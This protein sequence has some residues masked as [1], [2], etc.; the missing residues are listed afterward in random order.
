MLW[1]AI[2]EANIRG[3]NEKLAET[4]GDL[5]QVSEERNNFRIMIGKAVEFFEGNIFLLNNAYIY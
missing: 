3:I 2:C 5:K 4:K 1:L